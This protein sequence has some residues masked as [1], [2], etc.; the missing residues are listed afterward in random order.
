MGGA[1]TIQESAATST[2]YLL[3]TSGS[4]VG[5]QQ[6][7]GPPLLAATGPCPGASQAVTVVPAVTRTGDRLSQVILQH[8]RDAETRGPGLGSGLRFNF[9]K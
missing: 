8:T 2:N 1:V 3:R 6:A 9:I 7:Q 4:R 5:A